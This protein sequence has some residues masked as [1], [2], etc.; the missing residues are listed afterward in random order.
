[1]DQLGP[2]IAAHVSERRTR[3]M[4]ALR[5]YILVLLLTIAAF[6]ATFHGIMLWVEGKSYSALTCVYWTI[7]T[8]TTLGYGDIVFDSD[9]GRIFS[10]LVVITGIVM[11]LIVLPFAIIR[12]YYTPSAP[13]RVRPEMH[14]HVIITNYDGIGRGLI[15][16]LKQ[17]DVPYVVVEPDA[18]AAEDLHSHGVSVVTGNRDAAE[19]YTALRAHHASLVLANCSD[20][21]NTN[22]VLT[23]RQRF[24]DV[25]IA[26]TA[27]DDD[28]GDILRDS[29]ATHVLPLHRRLGEFLA[30][31]VEAG[32][33]HAHVSGRYEDLLIAEFPVHNTP[34]RDRSLRDTRLRQLTGLSVVAMWEHGKIGPVTADTVLSDYSVPVIVGTEDQIAYLDA[35]FVIYNANENPVI[36]V[37]GGRT[38]RSAAVALSERELAVHVIERSDSMRSLVEPIAD[39][40][41]IGDARERH[42][43][44][45]AGIEDAPSV[46]LTTG[47]DAT[48]IYLAMLCRRLNPDIRVVSRLSSDRNLETMRTAGVDFML[49]DTSLGVR[50]VMALMESRELVVLGEGI[51]MLYEPVPRSL[52]GKTLGDSGIG[53][54][55][56]LN[57][58]AIKTGDDV[59]TAPTASTVLDPKA[60][61]VMLGTEAQHAAFLDAYAPP[62][63]RLKLL[64]LS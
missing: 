63:R 43:L 18:R 42:V 55:T 26:A 34:L 41:V 16:R 27:V 30:N 2:Q 36:V 25:P 58:I 28:A 38:G 10:L 51:D 57:V 12:T 54:T 39:E 53:A 32:K 64:T 11:L 62:K 1:M 52:A 59:D 23:L 40:V 33:V 9:V 7:E 14:G 48:N 47:D 21:M 19:T 31:R 6:A 45:R 37:G 22:I 24:P 20:A 15:Q 44:L 56:G 49:S 17:I 50:S 5:R 60:E 13:T 3:N 4:A 29:G 61:L 35:M 46:V 8:M